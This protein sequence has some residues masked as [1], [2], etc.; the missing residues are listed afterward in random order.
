MLGLVA[1]VEEWPT[2]IGAFF[3]VLVLGALGYFAVRYAKWIS[4]NFVLTN[5]RLVYRFGVIAKKGIEIPLDK[6]N[7]V[8]FDQTI[9][10]RMMGFGS[11]KIESASETGS[12]LFED[13]R[14]PSLVQNEIYVQMDQ[15]MDE[16]YDRIGD[17]VRGSVT[18]SELSIPEQIEKLDELRGRGVISD[19]EFDAK[20]AQLLDRM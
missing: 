17:A 13:I 11:L 16:Q 15:R 14:K 5:D 6:V 2:W 10:G 20:K 1:L 3:G 9:F 19:E 12:Q 4:T 18:S 7:T 8:F